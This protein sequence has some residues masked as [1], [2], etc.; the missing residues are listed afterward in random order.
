MLP[1]LTSLY[2]DWFLNTCGV[3]DISLCNNYKARRPVSKH[4][5]VAYIKLCNEHKVHRNVTK[6]HGGVD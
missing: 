2:A 4:R 3:T 1:I 5:S 6:T